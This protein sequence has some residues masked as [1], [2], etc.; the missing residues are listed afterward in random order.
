MTSVK[1]PCLWKSSVCEKCLDICSSFLESIIWNHTIYFFLEINLTFMQWHR[2]LNK[3]RWIF[4][5]F[6]ITTKVTVLTVSFRICLWRKCKSLRKQ[7]SILENSKN[8]ICSGSLEHQEE[9][10]V[11]TSQKNATPSAVSESCQKQTA[12]LISWAHDL[13]YA[14]LL[15]ISRCKLSEHMVPWTKKLQM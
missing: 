10:L 4:L 12:G 7:G 14:F 3:N 9:A 5:L 13:S 1:K 2:L 11:A 8:W 6:G 15:P